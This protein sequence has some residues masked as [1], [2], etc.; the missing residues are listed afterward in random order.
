MKRIVLILLVSSVY[1]VHQDFWNWTRAEPLLFDF[2]PI[3]LWFHA[4]YSLLASALMWLL[5]KFAWPK[6]L[7]E[8]ERKL[9]ETDTR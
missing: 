2:L 7:E 9:P 6:S 3:G 5:V 1:L 8:I 4:A